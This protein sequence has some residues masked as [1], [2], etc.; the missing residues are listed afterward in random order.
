MSDFLKPP[1][2]L[3]FLSLYFPLD[4]K[5]EEKL[6]QSHVQNG[7]KAR[8]SKKRIIGIES[9]FERIKNIMERT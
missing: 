9:E 5:R 6:S 7:E 1:F 4:F 3:K 8:K 2:L